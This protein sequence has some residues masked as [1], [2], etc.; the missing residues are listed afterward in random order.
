MTHIDPHAG[1]Q[2][3]PAAARR[4]DPAPDDRLDPV[5]G[6]GVLLPAPPPGTPRVAARRRLP[7]GGHGDVVGEVLVDA[8]D[9]LVLL[10]HD[11]GPVALDPADVVGRRIVPARSVR[12]SSSAADVERI[13]AAGWPGVGAHRLGGW[14]VRDGLGWSGRANSALAAGDPGVGVSEALTLVA[15]HY[16]ALGQHPLLHLPHDIDAADDP[17]AVALEAAA[18]EGGWVAY[19]PTIVMVADLRRLPDAT[20][21]GEPPAGAPTPVTQGW[22]EAPDGAWGEVVRGGQ[23]AAS[24]AARRVL[25][26]APARY[27]LLSAPGPEQ[28]T[29]TPAVVAAAEPVG[30]EPVGEGARGGVAAGRVVVTA[31]WAGISCVEVVP[32]LRR[33][34][35][36][37]M[38]TR[39]LLARARA[40]GARF[41]YL[42][43]REPNTAAVALYR[44]LGFTEHHR[45][46]YRRLSAP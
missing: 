27:L 39:L 38:I 40:D 33:R 15:A 43:V 7:E 25:T 19:E 41:A 4:H 28:T 17:A 24:D 26:S 13:A 16:R 31:D 21:T 6:P 44:G 29:R 23:I 20:G 10:P 37:A 34:G 3:D 9:R 8:P 2:S 18:R 32:A 11:R 14:L 36:G 35:L 30:A 46:H 45:Y 22:S 1:P 42:Q 5:T 12:P